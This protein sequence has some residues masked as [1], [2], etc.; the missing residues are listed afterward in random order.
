MSPHHV[1]MV[2]THFYCVTAELLGNPEALARGAGVK[3]GMGG[4]PG[5]RCP[6][7]MPNNLAGAGA[8]RNP[9]CDAAIFS[10]DKAL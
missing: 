8:V 1:L 4:D 7:V 5:F 6:A 3:V 9:S 2:R 10:H